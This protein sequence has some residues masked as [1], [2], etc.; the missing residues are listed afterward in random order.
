MPGAIILPDNYRGYGLP[1]L[2]IPGQTALALIINAN[3][4]QIITTV[5]TGL[6][7]LD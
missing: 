3:G 7:V 5:N 2:R 4:L 6:D 1:G